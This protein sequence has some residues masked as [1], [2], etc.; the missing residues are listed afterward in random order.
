M[1]AL[2]QQQKKLIKNALQ[3]VYDSKLDSIKQNSK[4]LTD[5]EKSLIVAKANEYFDLQ[6]YFD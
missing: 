5:E 6:N 4:I 1:K 3:Y 2:T